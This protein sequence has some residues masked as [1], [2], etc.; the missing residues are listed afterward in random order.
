MGSFRD[1]TR[2]STISPGTIPSPR[3]AWCLE[4]FGE[5]NV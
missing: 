4:Q 5:K 1:L 3:P 2:V